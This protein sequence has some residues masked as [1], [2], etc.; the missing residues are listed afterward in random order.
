MHNAKF[1]LPNGATRLVY[2]LILLMLAS[3]LAPLLMNSDSLE[4]V[5]RADSSKNNP[6][7]I[8][9]IEF[10]RSHV[11]W[12]E[13]I[14]V[15]F[16]LT[17]LSASFGYT[18]EWSI[19]EGNVSGICGADAYFSSDSNQ[20]QLANGS[21]QIMTGMGATQV[22]LTLKTNLSASAYGHNNGTYSLKAELVSNTYVVDDSHKA[23]LV[24]S[25]VG[26]SSNVAYWYTPGYS[27]GR[28]LMN[29]TAYLINTPI[30]FDIYI[31]VPYDPRPTWN[32]S[33]SIIETSSTAV[34]V[35]SGGIETYFSGTASY[36]SAKRG[37]NPWNN[38]GL[39]EISNSGVLEGS[40]EMTLELTQ[41]QTGLVALREVVPFE[42]LDIAF[43]GNENLDVTLSEMFPEWNESI[44]PTFDLTGLSTSV[45]YQVDWS[46]CTGSRR[47]PSH[48]CTMIA[49]FQN[50]SGTNP[51]ATDT[52]TVPTSSS[53]Q[54]TPTIRTNL[55]T[56]ANS[57]QFSNGTFAI[58]ASLSSQGFIVDQMITSF[59]VVS[60]PDGQNHIASWYTPGESNS[61]LVL[62][63]SGYLPNH[64]ISLDI[65]IHI[66]CEPNPE[67]N[68]SWTIF[69]TNGANDV[70]VFSSGV[71]S[72]FQCTNSNINSRRGWYP[73]TPNNNGLLELSTLGLAEGDYRI[74]LAL[75]QNNS[76]VT[77]LVKSLD[78]HVSDVTITGNEAFD[79]SLSSN[80]IGWDEPLD[81]TFDLSGLDSSESYDI[82]WQICQGNRTPHGSGAHQYTDCANSAFFRDAPW[83]STW[84]GTKA[85][86]SESITG[87]SS[88]Q[89]TTSI[90]TNLSRY[91]SGWQYSNGTFSLMA[92]L[93]SDSVPFG[94]EIT[95]TFL[96]VNEVDGSSQIA[97]WNTP[98]GN[99]V[100][101]LNQSA[102]LTNTPVAID[103]WIGAACDPTSEWNLSW[104]FTDLA[105][106][107]VLE[108]G[109]IDRSLSCQ[110]GSTNSATGWSPYNTD[111]G[112][113]E[114]STDGFED[115]NYS[116]KI[117]LIQNDSGVTT[118][119]EEIEFRVVGN[120]YLLDD[121]SMSL[122]TGP[123]TDN[124]GDYGELYAY[125]Q[126]ADQRIDEWYNVEWTV[127]D[128]TDWSIVDE[129]E[130]AYLSIF[131]TYNRNISSPTIG[132]IDVSGYC[133][134]ATL[135]AGE[136]AELFNASSCS[137]S[138][139]DSDDDDVAD[140][141]DLCPNTEAGWVVDADGCA[142]NQL[143]EDSDGYSNDID[144]CWGTPG[145]EVVD[146]D[147]CGESQKDDDGDNIMN[148]VDLCSNTNSGVSV[149]SDGCST[150]QLTDTDN[151]GLNNQDDQCPNTPG[152]D[153]T[154]V[155]SY[156]CG[157]HQR[158]TDGDGTVDADDLCPAT[159]AGAIVVSDGCQSTTLDSDGDNIVDIDD[160]CP[161]TA[162]GETIDT[163]G[164]AESQKDDDGDSVMN[165]VDLCDQTD[166][167]W[168]TDSDGCASY[169][170]DTDGDG[171]T[172]DLD[173]CPYTPLGLTVDTMGCEDTDSDGV[174]E[175]YDLC[176]NTLPLEI[177]EVDGDGCAP[178]QKDTDADG[179]NDRDDQC[180]TVPGLTK[181]A[182][183]PPNMPPVCAVY[184]SAKVDGIVATG[185]A[186]IPTLDL[187]IIP[188]IDLPTG[189]YYIV[190]KCWD[191]DGSNVT[192]NLNGMEQEGE[193][194]IVGYIV[195]V[196]ENTE[197]I[198]INAQFSDGETT[199]TISLK[200]RYRSDASV[201][202]G[203]GP[204]ATMI[205]ILGAAAFVQHRR[206][207]IV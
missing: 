155:D 181:R 76:S 149:D 3:A 63:Q 165:D 158:D 53:T 197:P 94:Y 7:G 115:G 126:M 157:A 80:Y 62:N 207:L 153:L 92:T 202:P 57:D 137:T 65:G 177:T 135:Y 38:I 161:S 4:K 143:D 5:K 83:G 90:R 8:I 69:D 198:E 150:A 46:I 28:I 17:N 61:Q 68:L 2:L 72:N 88:S 43:T 122:E 152:F 101:N 44:D 123:T 159:P 199:K 109:G 100:S 116:V 106:S 86:G 195:K 9:E 96:V 129:G 22:L 142:M 40:Y 182:G 73:Q 102:Y 20:N 140:L 99:G 56:S 108:S 125:F 32:V 30:S 180:P 74:D 131:S 154:T 178:S 119:T 114:L 25:E 164:C 39:I 172:N 128:P 187:T 141:V 133:L 11:G 162:Q 84:S 26:G 184:A 104:T 6:T 77:V 34:I 107:T 151:D 87:V 41:V 124:G 103:L 168:P 194:V 82:D 183:C 48:G 188:I 160:L 185:D 70:D 175:L 110:A 95:K 71:D 81:I 132:P 201:T 206:K 24:T 75:I 144:W 15:T 97:Y 47:T 167:N 121:S 166:P 190:L 111:N 85:I 23:F 18:I 170:L 117:D 50:A 186:V 54:F 138:I 13:S 204:F 113:L 33:W 59:L 51:L 55:T 196:D 205:G 193:E 45:Q 89:I 64:P 42:V 16:T 21:E 1:A 105:D 27:N 79:F 174:N 98:G 52:E 91:E 169:Q 171:V 10:N 130:F 78:V 35:N 29:Q 31:A 192:V 146:T 179:V 58:T 112:L 120:W 12:N 134:N 66:A 37:W 156:G 173:E 93:T 139:L 60:N 176:P 163:Y 19:C 118:L 145:A 147:G 203:F 14:L 36:L 189:E 200:V 191:E 127:L 136:E 148:D 49:Y 67:W